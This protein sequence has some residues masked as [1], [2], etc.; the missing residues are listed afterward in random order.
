MSSPSISLAQHA[1]RTP[2]IHPVSVEQLLTKN[3]IAQAL[4][5]STRV[6]EQWIASGKLAVTRPGGKLVRISAWDFHDFLA[7]ARS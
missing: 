1:D 3:Q 7:R 6:V 2:I 5:V 4:Q